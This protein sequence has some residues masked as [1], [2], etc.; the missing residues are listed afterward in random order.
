MIPF[1]LWQVAIGPA[2][3]LVAVT[4][5]GIGLSI[6][7]N[8]FFIT[9]RMGQYQASVVEVKKKFESLAREFDELVKD[10]NEFR[11]RYAAWTGDGNGRD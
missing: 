3:A 6:V 4:L 7:A 2:W 5:G 1:V 8:F 9:Y 10:Y 11:R